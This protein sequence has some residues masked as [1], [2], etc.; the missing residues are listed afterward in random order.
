LPGLGAGAPLAADVRAFFEPRFDREF[1]DVRIHTGAR[2]AASAHSLNAAAYARGRDVV[3]GDGQYAPGTGAGRRLLAH[4]LAHVVQQSDDPEARQRIHRQ[5]EDEEELPDAPP[6][7]EPLPPFEPPGPEPEF[8][9]KFDIF[10]LEGECCAPVPGIGRIC[11]PDPVT[12]M[13]KIE[14]ALAKMGKKKPRRVPK[15]DFCPPNRQIPLDAPPPLRAG[16]CCSDGTFWNGFRCSPVP[17]MP[18]CTPEKCK[19]GEI[20]VGPPL[21][22]IPRGKKEPPP[23]PPPP[24]KEQVI[25]SHEVFFQFDRPAGEAGGST[26]LDRA[27]TSEGKSNFAMLVEQLKADP[28]LKVQ[29][30]GAASTEGAE[31]Y[32]FDLARRRAIA[33]ADALERAG[34]DRSRVADPAENDLRGE[35]KPVGTGLRSCG[36]IGA[37]GPSDR[38]VLARVFGRR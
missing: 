21:C 36:E 29:L 12:L 32:N 33:V 16:G 14:E 35:C 18:S 27:L 38:R 3:F 6:E 19:E 23:P 17:V 20:F 7:V 8:E 11:A 1:G 28:D 26:E 22:C 34:I 4:E 31:D 37:A 9:C 10:K 5:P 24:T 2:A 25:G 13:K 30:I 15:I